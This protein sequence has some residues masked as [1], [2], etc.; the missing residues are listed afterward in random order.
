MDKI[1][2]DFFASVKVPQAIEKQEVDLR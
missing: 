2:L 1:L